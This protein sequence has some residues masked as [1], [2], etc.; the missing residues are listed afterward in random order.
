MPG[1]SATVFATY[2][3]QAAVAVLL[4]TFLVVFHRRYRRDHLLHWAWSWWALAVYLATGASSLALATEL[5]PG[6]PLRLALSSLSLACSYL[7]AGWLLVGAWEIAR[8]L[9]MTQRRISLWLVLAAAAGATS[10]MLFVGVGGTGAMRFMVRVGIRSLLTGIAF[11][12]AAWVIWRVSHREG[13]MGRRVLCGAFVAYGLQQAQY[14]GAALLQLQGASAFPRY[15]IYLGYVEVFLQALIALG[16]TI[17]LLEEEQL[18]VVTA[19]EEL[20]RLAFHDPLTGLANRKLLLD[21]LQQ[22]LAVARRSGEGLAVVVLDLDRLKVVNETL[23]Y[24]AGDELMRAAAQRLKQEIRDGDTAAR[25]GGHE[26]ALVLPSMVTEPALAEAV[27]RLQRRLGEPYELRVHQVVT[28]ISAGTAWFPSDGDDGET[29]LRRASASLAQARAEGPGLRR[30]W[31]GQAEPLPARRMAEEARLRQALPAGELVLYYQPVVS[32][33]SGNMVCLE[34]L[35]RWQHPEHG[36]QNPGQF[37]PLAES[38]GLT[39]GLDL[40]A[41]RTACRELRHL[42]AEGLAELRMAVNLSARTFRHPRLLATITEALMTSGLPA[43]SLELEVTETVA[44]QDVES[45]RNVLRTL[46]EVG[47]RIALDDFGT[48]YSS[49]S[50][51]RTFPIDTLKIDQSFI[52]D[53]GHGP[54]AA[55]LTAAMVALGHSLHLTVVAEGVETEEQRMILRRQQCDQMQGFLFARPLPSE[56]CRELLLNLQS[57]SP[58]RLRAV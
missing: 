20:E 58:S 18:R 17:W 56:A 29:L 50:Y 43:D 11:V 41:L 7:Q 42:H 30:S 4:A 45:T 24:A 2:L 25:L 48:G 31:A 3:L 34:A 35:L 49:L 19:S 10:S 53:L 57:R 15:S 21:R 38:L 47:I 40:W 55:A 14:F 37:L 1:G 33:A 8:A 28:S 16:I 22:A 44:M 23:G 51:L 32:L 39:D 6:H 12:A 13:R 36:L 26:L 5:G 52:R 9:P 27:E 46:K 54:E